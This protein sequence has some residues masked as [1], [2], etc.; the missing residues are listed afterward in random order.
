M[1][2]NASYAELGMIGMMRKW[3]EACRL[4]NTRREHGLSYRTLQGTL[5]Q[6]VPAALATLTMGLI[7]EQAGGRVEAQAGEFDGCAHEITRQVV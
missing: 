3:M 4:R 1:R 6:K 2:R 7:H 5:V